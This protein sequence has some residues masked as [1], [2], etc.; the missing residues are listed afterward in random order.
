MSIWPASVSSSAVSSW[1]LL[2][3]AALVLVL[4]PSFARSQP[5]AA[6]AVR[7]SRKQRRRRLA[8]TC[9][10]SPIDADRVQSVSALTDSSV[11][12]LVGRSIVIDNN[13]DE[14]DTDADSYDPI[15]SVLQEVLLD[16][17]NDKSD[18]P[19]GYYRRHGPTRTIWRNRVE[20]TD[21]VACFQRYREYVGDAHVAGSELIVRTDCGGRSSTSDLLGSAESRQRKSQLFRTAEK[22]RKDRLFRPL[23]TVLT[24][25]RSPATAAS[26]SNIPGV[27]PSDAIDSAAQAS[28]AAVVTITSI[29]GK[30]VTGTHDLPSHANNDG[31][32][33]SSVSAVVPTAS[34]AEAS[35]ILIG[36]LG[37]DSSPLGTLSVGDA[38]GGG[39]GAVHIRVELQLA[40]TVD[41]DRLV[42]TAINGMSTAMVDAHTLEVVLHCHGEE[43]GIGGGG[44]VERKLEG[45]DNNNH[46]QL[47]HN[48]G[49]TSRRLNTWQEGA[50]CTMNTLY[51]DNNNLE[52]ECQQGVEDPTQYR[53]GS[54]TPLSYS[55][56]Q[57]CGC[58]IYITQYCYPECDIASAPNGVVGASSAE[59]SPTADAHY[60]A[61]QTLTYIRDVLGVDGVGSNSNSGETVPVFTVLYPNDYREPIPC[62]DN[63]PEWIPLEGDTTSAVLLYACD[64]NPRVSVDIVAHEIMHGV[65]YFSS[66]LSIGT[67]LNLPKPESFGLVEGFSDIL[68]A[69]ME[70]TISNGGDNPDFLV[71]EEADPSNIIRYME[72]PD[73]TEA[74]IDSVC[75]SWGQTGFYTFGPL[76]KAY[77]VSVRWLTDNTPSNL[78][79][80]ARS[81]GEVFLKSNILGLSPDS[82]FTDAAAATY[83]FAQIISFT[84]FSAQELTEALQQ[85]WAAVDISL[86]SAGV[87]TETCDNCVLTL[88]FLTDFSPGEIWELTNS[89]GDIIKA[90]GRFPHANT[91]FNTTFCGLDHGTYNF[92]LYDDHVGTGIDNG[93]FFKWLV[94]GKLLSVG[95]NNFINSS[96]SILTI[97]ENGACVDSSCDCISGYTYDPATGS[98]SL[99]RNSEDQPTTLPS[100]Q[101][102]LSP[103]ATSASPSAPPSDEPSGSPS[104]LPSSSPSVYVSVCSQATYDSSL[105]APRCSDGWCC[106]SGPSLLDAVGDDES[107]YPNT[108]DGCS[109][110]NSGSYHS[111]E[112]IDALEVYTTDGSPFAPGKEVEVKATVYAWS[113][114]SADTADFYYSA[115]ANAP[116]WTLI[117]S[118]IPPRGGL[119]ILTARYSL[120]TGGENHLQ[121]V[122]VNFRYQGSES[123]CNT[124]SG[125]DDRDDLLFTVNPV[126]DESEGPSSYPSAAPSV[127]VVPSQA[128]SSAPSDEPSPEP[129]ASLPPSSAPSE[130]PTTS[131]EP[132]SASPTDIPSALPSLRPSLEPSDTPSSLPTS[133][134]SMGPSDEPSSAPTTSLPPSSAPSVT[135]TETASPTDIPSALPS[136]FPSEAPSGTPSSLPTLSPSTSPS[137]N[138]SS[139]QPSLSPSASPSDEPSDPTPADPCAAVTCDVIG[140]VAGLC[141]AAPTN[142]L[143]YQCLWF[144]DFDSD[145]GGWIDGGSDAAYSNGS[146]RIRDN[147][148]GLSAF[149]TNYFDVSAFSTITVGFFY[150]ATGMESGEDF[151]LEFSVVED[152]NFPPL[153]DTDGD[154]GLCEGDC[155]H[156]SDCGDGQICFQR[157]RSEPVPGC[158][159][160]GTDRDDYCIREEND[161]QVQDRWISGS[162]FDNESD[163]DNVSWYEISETNANAQVIDVS[164]DNYMAL[165]FRCDA[166]RND[167]M[168]YIDNV[169]VKGT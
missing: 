137:D 31:A 86:T 103:S 25:I 48:P 151:L 68:G 82:L 16:G 53:L 41:G 158:T 168:V 8:P 110:G 104:T 139:S 63:Q 80:C 75:D 50:T 131:F 13:V 84:A 1:R 39:S 57:E 150:F 72:N 122:R 97:F 6:A 111:D 5:H 149:T 153:V 32:A 94:D 143:G 30:R 52:A 28:A 120:P 59:G 9:A 96:V 49:S 114:G 127:S 71:G 163:L 141:S 42:Y 37:V 119:Q 76:T 121:A 107:N 47:S 152:L 40:P 165:R 11:A 81:I 105:G 56:T 144:H 79:E 138:P 26:S 35:Q 166:S 74:H 159:G 129:T 60:A 130:V 112:S 85:G 169:T 54:I 113:D 58:N 135:P 93:A 43:R 90:S 167:D 117:G 22:K 12:S 136:L 92:T 146:L 140:N 115:D 70:F 3:A 161:W 83:D 108:I 27:L 164:L 17:G 100:S 78:S 145:A 23:R 15:A 14:N 33:T 124:N 62:L 126:P 24:N 125:Y 65:T 45:Y 133:S 154:L 73:P 156:N 2:V 29:T 69:V 18:V 142:P 7:T 99:D 21:P 66:G 4:S 46:L 10:G 116:T 102:S 20:K 51:L 98:C 162:D 95:S 123:P 67:T 88:N 55:G 64:D 132:T 118:M 101:P 36:L 148:K 109:D 106:N 19:H 34:R 61:T 89:N 44:E 134:P 128:P 91:V 147:S 160:S 77:V 157:K 155:R 87:A 38:A